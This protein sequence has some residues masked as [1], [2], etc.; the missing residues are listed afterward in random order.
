MKYIIEI[1]DDKIV[2]AEE[3]FKSVSF[4][5]AISHLPSEKALELNENKLDYIN[6]EINGKLK[7]KLKVITQLPKGLL[8]K[9]IFNFFIGILPFLIISL[10]MCVFKP[11]PIYG[12]DTT[13]WTGWIFLIAYSIFASISFSFTIWLFVKIGNLILSWIL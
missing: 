1:P 8:H 4:V 9:L 3:L 5:K 11:I 7:S 2:F 13:W 6:T 10:I 12:A